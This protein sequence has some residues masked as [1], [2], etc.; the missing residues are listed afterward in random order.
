M[1]KL[2]QAWGG[3]EAGSVI[4]VS[5]DEQEYLVKEGIAVVSH[6][7]ASEAAPPKEV[8]PKPLTVPESIYTLRDHIRS[9]KAMIATGNKGEIDKIGARLDEILAWLEA[10]HDDKRPNPRSVATITEPLPVPQPTTK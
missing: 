3:H 1:V 5:A 7:P 6:G 4:S 8:P 10:V 9:V 2:K